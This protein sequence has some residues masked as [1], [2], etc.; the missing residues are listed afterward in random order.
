MR[1]FLVPALILVIGA[2][3][4]IAGMWVGQR[5]ARIGIPRTAGVQR[6]QTVSQPQKAPPAKPPVKPSTEIAKA[7]TKPHAKPSPRKAPKISKPTPDFREFAR[8]KVFDPAGKALAGAE[9][10]IGG[11]WVTHA[12]TDSEGKFRIEVPQLE[13]KPGG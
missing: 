6:E 3:I 7:A 10:T 8:G 4:F 13:W 9:V 2:W 11:A 1:S 12:V 5:Q